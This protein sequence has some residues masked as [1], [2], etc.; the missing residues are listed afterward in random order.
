MSSTPINSNILSID[1]ACSRTAEE[2]HHARNILRNSQSLP[3]VPVAE[4]VAPAQDIN[5][6]IRQLGREKPRRDG[7]AGDVSG[8]QLDGKIAR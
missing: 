4:L 5:Q 7:V 8:A 3:R 1:I 6:A 2:E